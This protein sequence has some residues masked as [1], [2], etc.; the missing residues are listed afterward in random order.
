MIRLSRISRPAATIAVTIPA[1]FFSPARGTETPP[2]KEPAADSGYERTAFALPEKYGGET[3]ADLGFMPDGKLCALTGSGQVITATLKPDK[4]GKLSWQ[5]FSDHRVAGASGIDASNPG[6]VLVTHSTGVSALFDTD[7]DGKADF[8]KA[9]LSG[10]KMGP[11]QTFFHGNPWADDDGRLWF[12][13][14]GVGNHRLRGCI[15]NTPI[16]EPGQLTLWASGFTLPSGLCRGPAG[17]LLTIDAT[18]TGL[19]AMPLYRVEPRAF[20][21]A[22]RGLLHDEEI[23]K[24]KGFSPEKWIAAHPDEYLK[25]RLKPAVWIPGDLR[26][27]KPTRPVFSGNDPDV[28]K[29]WANQIFV[30]GTESGSVVRILVDGED[31]A[32]QGAAVNFLNP[33]LLDGGLTALEIDRRNGALV[34]GQ[35]GRLLVIRPAEKPA[36]ALT[37]IVQ[38]NDGF[39]IS[40]NQAVDRKPAS[41]PTSFPVRI[42][43]CDPAPDRDDKKPAEESDL[44]PKAALVDSDGLSVSLQLDP[45]APGKV[46]A[47]DFSGIPSESGASLQNAKAYFTVTRK[48]QPEKSTL[49]E[50]LT[51]KGEKLKEEMPKAEKSEEGKDSGPPPGP[52]QSAPPAPAEDAP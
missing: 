20:A 9:M 16:R 48:P 14:A 28:P 12:A 17:A 45:V 32:W 25:K 19:A 21:G 49:S 6:V 5:I 23:S 2:E 35:K 10:W 34:V 42:F 52:K 46:V 24:E 1:L 50:F 18:L 4:E 51:L 13:L 40:F 36:F 8:F 33:K 11:G 29:D 31:A 38:A 26:V 44:T 37:R 7:D 15:L 27:T 3:I 30:G 39:V 43:A 41:D 22:P 47:F